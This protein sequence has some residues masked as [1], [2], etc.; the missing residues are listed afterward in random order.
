MLRVEN[1]NK[2]IIERKMTMCKNKTI[3]L[4]N[5]ILENKEM[6]DYDIAVYVSLRNLYAGYG[7][8]VLIRFYSASPFAFQIFMVRLFIDKVFCYY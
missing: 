8:E 4:K 1:K 3:F 7:E 5:E 6:S 2:L